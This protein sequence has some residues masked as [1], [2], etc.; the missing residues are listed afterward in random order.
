MRVTVNAHNGQTERLGTKRLG[1]QVCRGIRA[2]KSSCVYQVIVEAMHMP[3][4]GHML[5]KRPKRTV[6]FHFCSPSG[7]TQAASEGRVV[8]SLAKC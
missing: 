5:R 1:K 6:G 8:N 7:S 4:D 3:R 2:F